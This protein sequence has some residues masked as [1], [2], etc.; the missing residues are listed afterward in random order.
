MKVEGMGSFVALRS[1]IIMDCPRLWSL[2]K[3]LP[4]LENL[5]IMKCESLDLGN[6]NIGEAGEGDNVRA[7]F[8]FG[9]LQYLFIY[10]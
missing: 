3:H 10:G 2:P 8:G 1:L 9:S 7:E 4:G 6:M 5:I